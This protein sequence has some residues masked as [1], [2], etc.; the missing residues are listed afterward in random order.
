MLIEEEQI[1]TIYKDGKQS[2]R[3]VLNR[4]QNTVISRVML[5][6]RC[7]YGKESNC[8]GVNW[9]GSVLRGC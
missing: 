9:M 7:L 6:W 3:I 2:S 5:A 4:R 8:D 1:K